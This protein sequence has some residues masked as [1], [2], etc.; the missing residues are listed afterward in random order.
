MAK[1][2]YL[3]LLIAAVVSPLAAQ[4]PDVV[5]SPRGETVERTLS[6]D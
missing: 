1:H 3:W 5:E 2:R 4:T 6:T